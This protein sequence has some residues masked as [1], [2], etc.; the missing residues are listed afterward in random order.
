[1][2]GLWRCAYSP[3]VDSL[4]E[5]KPPEKTRPS[6]EEDVDF[7]RVKPEPSVLPLGE[8]AALESLSES[9]D[10]WEVLLPPNLLKKDIL[11]DVEVVCACKGCV[12][13]WV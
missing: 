9:E 4:R 12:V 8:L 10:R 1:M 11:F 13:L 6:L 7:V 5:R 2:K 3:L